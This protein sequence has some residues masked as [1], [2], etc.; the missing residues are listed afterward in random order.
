MINHVS[1]YTVVPSL[2]FAG[3]NP[4]PKQGTGPMASLPEGISR[5]VSLL[6]NDPLIGN[7][8]DFRLPKQLEMIHVP[9][10][11]YSIPTKEQIH[12]VL[13]FIDE[14]IKK[15]LPVYV[16]CA[17]GLGRT[18]VVIA[19]FLA[20]YHRI[21]GEQ[22]LSMLTELRKNAGF[23]LDYDSPETH[24]QCTFVMTLFPGYLL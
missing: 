6:E 19:C 16:S 20:S 22:A 12:V 7:S 10:Q 1:W 14:S 8:P 4:L 18:G 13:S 3:S 5:W 15:S 9:I 11:D 24:E 17:H 2:V 21:S 23:C